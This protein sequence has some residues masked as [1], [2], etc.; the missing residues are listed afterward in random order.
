MLASP[1]EGEEE[2]ITRHNWLKSRDYLAV[3]PPTVDSQRIHKLEAEPPGN[4]V[5]LEM[6]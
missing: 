6:A 2:A 3:E 1:A 5:L 4:A